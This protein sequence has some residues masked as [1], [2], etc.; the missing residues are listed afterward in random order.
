MS[1]TGAVKFACEHIAGELA[2]FRGFDELN[3][4]RRRLLQLRMIGVDTNG[5]GFGNLSIRG[6][7]ASE[8]YITGSGTGGRAQLA[9][10]DYAKVTNYNLEKNWLR[11]KGSTVASS[12]SLTHAAVY[13]S[14]LQIAA[15]IHC[16]TNVLW[17]RLLTRGLTTAADVEYGTPEMAFD[18]QRLFRETDVRDWQIF[19]MAGHADGVIAFG[20]DV[21]D[22]FSALFQQRLDASN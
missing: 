18:V 13:E 9:L 4:C 21:D 19:A 1:E 15:V 17:M 7:D 6:A 11:C 8:F 14:D 12:E 2:P 10:A 20:K 22:A 3:A 5:I 16:H